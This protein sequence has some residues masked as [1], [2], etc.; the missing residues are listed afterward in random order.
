MKGRRGQEIKLQKKKV[1]PTS[2]KGNERLTPRPGVKLF[3]ENPFFTSPKAPEYASFISNVRLLVR[4]ITRGDLKEMRRIM[5]SDNRYIDPSSCKFKFSHADGR[6]PDSVAI[7]CKND[8]VRQEYFKLRSQLAADKSPRKEPNLLQRRTTGR[9]NFYMLGRATRAVEMTRGGR[10]GNN[11]FLKFESGTDSDSG[12]QFLIE[13]GLS[14]KELVKLSKEANIT[15]SGREGNNAFLKVESGTDS[16]SGAQFLIENGLSYKELVKLSK[17]AN[18]TPTIN[19]NYMDGMVVV[20]A[21]LGLREMASAFAE[22]PARSNMNDLH[23]E[24]LKWAFK[25]ILV[26]KA[27]CLTGGTLPERILPVSVLKKGY[28]NANI[29]PLHTA[30]INPNVKVRFTEY[31]SGV[32]VRYRTKL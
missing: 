25:L 15:P 30:A 6:S 16:D 31:G 5:R 3:K 11:A 22:G 26:K 9:S 21:R 32:K 29:T 20:A 23:R 4:A 18:I 14:Y 19:L 10:E 13:N 28:N 24:T 7:F 1:P 8:A 17:E 12:A 27:Q 2:K